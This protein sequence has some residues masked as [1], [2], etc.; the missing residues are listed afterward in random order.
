[1]GCCAIFPNERCL[2]TA[3]FYFGASDDNDD[4]LGHNNGMHMYLYHRLVLLSEA[5]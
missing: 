4:G 5:G 3:S 2:S 1:V